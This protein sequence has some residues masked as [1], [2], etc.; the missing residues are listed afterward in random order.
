MENNRSNEEALAAH[1]EAFYREVDDYFSKFDSSH[2]L[3]KSR[4]DYADLIMFLS[5][6]AKDKTVKK[7]KADYYAMKNYVV[8]QGR[9]I[10]GERDYLISKKVYEDAKDPHGDVDIL[11]I[12]RLAVKEDL[13]EIIRSHHLLKQHAGMRNTWES[14]RRSYSNVSRDVVNKYVQLCTCRVNQRLPSRPEGIKPILSKT[15][16]DRGQI[17]LIDMQS[18]IY[19]GYTWILH[20]QDHLTKFSYLRPLRNKLVSQNGNLFFNSSF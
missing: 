5:G 9:S 2:A 17:D 20:Y 8:M 7:S 18:N 13:F 10:T 19:D 4:S 12:K 14:I 6:P 15:F 16:N 11:K 3:V 1:R